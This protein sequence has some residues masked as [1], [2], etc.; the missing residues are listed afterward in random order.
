MNCSAV[1][2]HSV[3]GQHFRFPGIQWMGDIDIRHTQTEANTNHTSPPPPPSSSA[4]LV[5]SFP[6]GQVS[7]T[8]TT[9]GENVP[10]NSSYICS[11]RKSALFNRNQT[12]THFLFQSC[13][14]RDRP[15][16]NWIEPVVGLLVPSSFFQ[17]SSL[18]GLH[19]VT[20]ASVCLEPETLGTLFS[21]CSAASAAAAALVV[22]I[23]SPEI[24]ILLLLP[25]WPTFFLPFFL[26]CFY[27]CCCCN[28][29][30]T[31]AGSSRNW[32]CCCRFVSAL[33]HCEVLQIGKS[34]EVK[35]GSVEQEYR[36]CVCAFHFT[37]VNFL[38]YENCLFPLLFLET[39]SLK[40]L[41]V[42]IVSSS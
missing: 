7:Q 11:K 14:C 31:F 20:C 22:S 37:S 33:I 16:L 21:E 9:A 32:G 42:V 4:S 1:C 13:W 15:N 40:K 38:P 2:V 18:S 17:C 23:G 35:K 3:I 36:R 27:F 6:L 19:W 39:I 25:I 28:Y 41:V 5:P 29:V 12:H 30:S 24:D 10:K 26:F 34:F 8:T